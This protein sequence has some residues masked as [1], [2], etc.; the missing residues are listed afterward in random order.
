MFLLCCSKVGLKGWVRVVQ[1]ERIPRER[2][3]LRQRH[4]GMKTHGVFQKEQVDWALGRD[5]VTF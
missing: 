3:Q 4:A 1:V 5:P 2:V